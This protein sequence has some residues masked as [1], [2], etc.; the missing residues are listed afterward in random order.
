LWPIGP[1]KLPSEL[2]GIGQIGVDIIVGGASIKKGDWAFGDADGIIFLETDA[3]PSVYDWAEKS[4][5][6]EE[7][8]SAEIEAGISLGDLL[9]IE[10]FL[11]E[12]ERNPRADFNKHLAKLGRAI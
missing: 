1:L 4:W 6:R 3:L 7:S 8:L 10:S 9:G 2:K 11:A 5:H 12:R